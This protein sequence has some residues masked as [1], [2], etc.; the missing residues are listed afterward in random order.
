[1]QTHFMSNGC[2]LGDAKK[3]VQIRWSQFMS[4]DLHA[5]NGKIQVDDWIFNGIG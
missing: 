2:V 1:M 5:I 4:F 3:I